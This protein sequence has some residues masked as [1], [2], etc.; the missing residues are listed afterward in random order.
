MA[1][2][3]DFYYLSSTGT[4]RIYAK[5]CLP[6][7]RPRGVI[8]IAHGISEHVERYCDFMSFL[9]DNGFV[10]AAND[11]LGHGRSIE[12]P[13]D[14]GVFAEK[15]G[16]S[17]AVADMKLLHD[18]MSER[19]PALPYI[20][21]G[22]SMG[23]FLTRNY[24]F[25]YPDAYTHAILSGTGQQ[26]PLVLKVGTLLAN[27]I[28][29]KNGPRSDGTTLNKLAFGSYLDRIPV[30]RTEFDWLSRDYDQVD[31]YVADPLC[32]FVASSSLYRDMMEGI[33]LISQPKNLEKMNKSVPVYFMS[34]DEDPVGDYGKGVEK[35][36]QAFC[37]AGM[38]D[39]MI[40][41]YPRGRHEMLNERNREDVYRDI[42][43][44]LNEK[45]G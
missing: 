19:Y 11:H 29:R 3:Q 8:Q 27:A 16:W 14:Q 38:R 40:R 41:L 13:E 4:N 22:H 24:L 30:P 35:A 42:L 2:F 1:T 39:V 10:V 32:G 26:N 33:G 37:K 12:R 45:V 6:E 43:N 31:R 36:Y 15:D 7:G 25:R 5:L 9:A 34:G 23:S 18:Q 20:F 21:F 44:W 17:Y 28:V